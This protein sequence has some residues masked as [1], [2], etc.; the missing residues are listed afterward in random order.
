M[1]LWHSEADKIPGPINVY[2][3]INQSLWQVLPVLQNISY[4]FKN[5]VTLE[6]M[7]HNLLNST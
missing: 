7:L 2:C 4:S 5:W 1:S 6:N 3:V